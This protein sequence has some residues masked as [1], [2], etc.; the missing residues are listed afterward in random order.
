MHPLIV[1]VHTWNKLLSPSICRSKC[2]ATGRCKGTAFPSTPISITPGPL[3]PPTCR[4][5]TPRDATADG[6]TCRRGGKMTGMHPSSGGGERRISS[7]YIQCSAFICPSRITDSLN[8]GEI[9]QSPHS[10]KRDTGW[11]VGRSGPQ[12]TP[13]YKNL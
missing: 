12:M 10:I 4:R 5:R 6:L 3:H 13:T 11:E 8:W 9:S 7:N 1:L 2:Q